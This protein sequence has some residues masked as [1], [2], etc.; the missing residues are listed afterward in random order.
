MGEFVCES[1]AFLE[2][3]EIPETLVEILRHFAID[4]VPET[5]AL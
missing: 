2:G 3:D 1:E 5:E 4:F